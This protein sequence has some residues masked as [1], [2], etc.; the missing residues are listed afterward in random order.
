MKRL[1]SA[2]PIAVLAAFRGAPAQA[3]AN[4]RSNDLIAVVTSGCPRMQ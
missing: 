1:L 2:A 3:A 4:R